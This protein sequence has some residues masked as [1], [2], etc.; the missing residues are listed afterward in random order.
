MVCDLYTGSLP[1]NATLLHHYNFG[2]KLFNCL[3]SLTCVAEL[4][5]ILIIQFD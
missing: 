4:G 2:L 3:I 1:K 5:Q